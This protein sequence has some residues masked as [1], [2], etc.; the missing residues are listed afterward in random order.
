MV[1]NLN[2]SNY[3]T[4]GLLVTSAYAMTVNTQ[5]IN[6]F[7]Y[8]PMLNSQT[9]DG[10]VKVCNNTLSFRSPIMAMRCLPKSALTMFKSW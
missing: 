8:V 3:I 4:T 2:Y 5:T 10:P 9:Y 7:G 6:L 1:I